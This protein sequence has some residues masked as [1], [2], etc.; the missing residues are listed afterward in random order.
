M[1]FII[2]PAARSDIVSI[3]DW[4]HQNF[5][6]QTLRRYKQLI[7]TA[8]ADVAANPELIGSVG[9]PEILANCRTY[10]LFHS[11]KKAGRRGNRIRNPRHFQLYRIIE[12]EVVEISRVLHDSTDLEQHLPEEYRNPVPE[13]T[14]RDPGFG[15]GV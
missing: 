12:R 7:Q 15:E 4:T 1:E 8:I 5:G 14:E 11:R 6:P 9:R 13:R 3:L 10:H 2:A